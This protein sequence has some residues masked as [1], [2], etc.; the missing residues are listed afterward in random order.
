MARHPYYMVDPA[1]LPAA[2]MKQDRRETFLGT[3]RSLAARQEKLVQWHVEQQHIARQRLGQSALR[4]SVQGILT[5]RTPVASKSQVASSNPDQKVALVAAQQSRHDHRFAHAKADRARKSYAPGLDLLI[6]GFRQRF[7]RAGLTSMSSLESLFKQMDI[8]K[9]G[10]LSTAE[11]RHGLIESGVLQNP[12]ECDLLFAFF[13][14]DRSGSIDFMEFLDVVRGSLSPV[15]RAVVK[16]AFDTLDVNHDGVITVDDLHLKHRF[17]AHPDVES[18]YRTEEDVLSDFLSHFDT[19]TPDGQVTFAEFERYYE[20][21]SAHVLSDDLFVATVRNAWHLPGAT[22]GECLRVRIT[23]G[24]PSR[25]RND[26][27]W[28]HH[29]DHRGMREES[30]YFSG[31]AQTHQEIVEIRP[32]IGLNQHDPRFRDLVFA[33]LEEMGYKNVV[34]FEVRYRR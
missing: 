24:E 1:L 30:H 16:E 10:R 20:H 28:R 31:I 29:T 22:G 4:H 13:D 23:Y 11:L 18:G 3:S 34:D 5:P 19:I 27:D 21:T 14:E 33:R 25:E 2:G 26:T 9:S 8:D 7:Q 12:D 6:D 17:F 32:H 15:R